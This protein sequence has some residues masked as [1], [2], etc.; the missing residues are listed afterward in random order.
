MAKPDFWRWQ[1]HHGCHG[2]LAR[3]G[4]GNSCHRTIAP[5]PGADLFVF[6]F[7]PD[8]KGPLIDLLRRNPDVKQPVELLPLIVLRLAKVAGVP[9]PAPLRSVG[10]HL[11]Q[12]R[13]FRAASA[14][15]WWQPGAA[16]PEA[17]MSQSL[18]AML[19]V[20]VGQ[21]IEF[22]SSGRAFPAR[23]VGLRRMDAIEEQRGGLVF[24]CTAF[25]G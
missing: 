24:P 3:S 17:V 8:Q 19:G 7:G 5:L 6:G 12:R 23:I 16:A 11:F 4:G 9:A 10:Q 25:A 14:G 22:R 21:T 1:S 2:R 18:A 20:K 13:A 15:R